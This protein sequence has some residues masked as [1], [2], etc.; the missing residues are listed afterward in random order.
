MFKGRFSSSVG[1]VGIDLGSR[2]VR[3]LQLRE[4]AGEVHAVGAGKIDTP[5][6]AADATGPAF[7]EQVK[8]VLST[9]GFAGRKCVISLRRGDLKVQSVRLPRMP[10][11]ELR[12]AVQWEAAQRFGFDRAAMQVDFIRTGAS[13]QG[14]ENREEVL[15]VASSHALIHASI[16]PLLEAG[17]RPIAIETDFTALAR[18]YSRQCRREADLKIVRAVIEVGSSGSTVLILRGDQI[19]FCKTIAIG[20]VQLDQA[21]ADH[22]QMELSAARGLRSARIAAACHMGETGTAIDPATDRAVFEAV[23]PLLGELVK[24][25]SLC[26]RYYGVTFR[27]KPPERLILSGG[28]GLEPKLDQMLGSACKIP[29]AYDDPAET[30]ISLVGEIRKCM[31][32]IPGPPS[33]WAVA[34]GLSLRGIH[35]SR[36]SARDEAAVSASRRGAA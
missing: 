8:A 18:T 12:Q 1:L 10:D 29:V 15:I 4:S 22:L 21:V 35:A 30:F 3:L 36:A 25:I 13:P 28:E 16:D 6:G 20:G 19:A 24:E 33:C 31:N 5:A 27:G 11:G 14:G 7:V 17:L 26:L 23:R 2:C 32:R 9:G 34:A